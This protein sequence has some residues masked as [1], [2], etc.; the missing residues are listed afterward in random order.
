VAAGAGVL[1]DKSALVRRHLAPVSAI[2]G[3]LFRRGDL[4]TCSVVDLEVLYSARSPTEYRSVLAVR[5]ARYVTLPMTQEICA[6]AVEV[7]STLATRSHHRGCGVSDLLIAACA[8]IYGAQLLHY[9]G[10]FDLIASVTGQPVR[11]VVP[12]GSVP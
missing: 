5:R 9:D 7:Q 4:A 12:R 1:V 6:R 2:L 10:D 3:P 8:E 11:W